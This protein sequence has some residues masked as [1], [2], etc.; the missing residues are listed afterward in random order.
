MKYLLSILSL[1]S[2]LLGQESLPIPANP[3]LPTE[4]QPATTSAEPVSVI[5]ENEENIPAAPEQSE[6][7]EEEA[8]KLSAN[9]GSIY[10]RPNARVMTLATPGIR[11][12]ILD[13]QGKPLAMTKI[14]WYPAL[15]FKQFEHNDRD[16]I[17]AWGRERIDAANATYGTKWEVSDEQLWEHYRY[18]RWMAMPYTFFVVDRQLKEKT[19]PQLIEG[20]I[21]HPIYHRYYPHGETAAHIL[22]Y[23]GIKGKLEKGPINYG[24]PIFPYTLGRAGL[25]KFFDKQLT[26]KRGL[27]RHQYASNGT[28]FPNEVIQ[29]PTVGGNV[30]TTLNLDWQKRAERV[31]KS[32]TKR[33][34]L[35]VID[36]QT[37]E[38]L[39]MA[40]QPSFDPNLFVP[41]ALSKDFNKLMN[42][43]DKP[44]YA[45]AFQGGYPPA[46][47]FKP[48]V[49]LA[50]L[51]N[52]YISR[53]SSIYCPAYLEHNK[54]KY[55]DWS[56]SAAGDLSVIPAIIR[57]NNPFFYILGNEMKSSV[58]IDFARRFGFGTKT[59]LPLQGE[60]AGNMPD[61]AWMLKYHRRNM[62]RGD[63]YNNA[64]GQ[65]ILISTPLQVAQAMAG[66][67]NGEYLPKLQL[68][69]QIQDAKGRVIAA[70]K[71]DAR[72]PLN[73]DP[74]HIS[75]VKEGMMKVVNSSWGT[76]KSGKLSFATLCGKTGTG[77]WK[78]A[79]DQY[80]AWF[81]G[82]FPMKEPKYAFAVLYEGEPGEEIS[83]GKKAAPIVQAFFNPLEKEIKNAISPPARAV[84]VVEETPSGQGGPTLVEDGDI[85]KAITI[86]PETG[87]EFIP[88][89]ALVAEEAPPQTE[90]ENIKNPENNAVT[91]A[92]SSEGLAPKT[93]PQPDKEENGVEEAPKKE[94]GS[95]E[96]PKEEERIPK[97]VIAFPN[98]PQPLPDP[99]FSPEQP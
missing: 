68:V 46:S 49:A 36:V 95:E 42:D 26:G 59:G 93:E 82:F 15:Q 66:I 77:Q 35:V 96:I 28:R 32:H 47:S 71:P 89:A 73:I 43:P 87:E 13:R 4:S 79:N 78:P 12:A 2:V 1:S 92:T 31:L 44:L 40:S 94:A 55:R 27:I 10:N 67:A 70:N 16:K 23:T 48:I 5:E 34:A 9:K 8:L 14:S 98:A 57:S 45:R 22:G 60:N 38:V 52:G 24:D 80:V 19:E 72:A 33:G 41:R 61:N 85:P 50:G 11:G 76:G 29:S 39:T 21:L 84:I 88:R 90:S 3:G 86:D 69:R 64:I 62:H 20:L 17:L 81:A 83:G 56:R 30:I 75:T 7:A 53:Y 99:P 63:H 97:A 54:H 74:K 51:Q 58:F 37:G 91:E 25:E 18:R 65:G 6:S